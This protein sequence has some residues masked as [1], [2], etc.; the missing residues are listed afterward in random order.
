MLINLLLAEKLLDLQ[1]PPAI[2][3]DLD[4]DSKHEKTCTEIIARIFSEDDSLNLLQKFFFDLKKRD[5][6]RYGLKDIIISLFRPTY[7]D[8]KDIPLPKLLIPIYYLVRPFLL[9]KRYGKSS[10]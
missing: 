5:N 10:I 1:L 4:A 7:A 6:L 8:F 3:D 2:L 9:L